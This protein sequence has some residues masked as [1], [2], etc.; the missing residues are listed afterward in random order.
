MTEA[1]ANLHAALGSLSEDDLIHLRRLTSAWGMLADFCFSDLVLYIQVE[2][3]VVMVNHI[4]PTTS[5][6]IYHSDLVGESRTAEQRPLVALAYQTGEKTAGE[7]DSVWLNN[8]IKVSCIPVRHNGRVIA[9]VAQ[10]SVLRGR[11]DPGELES[12]YGAIFDRFA[13]MIAAGVFPFSEENIHLVNMPRVGDG[14]VLVGADRSVEYTSPNA[15]SA[16]TRSGVDGVIRGTTLAES[17]FE[18]PSVRVALRTGRPTVDEVEHDDTVVAVRV[19][20]LLDEGAVTGA[21]VLLRDVTDLRRRDRLLLSKDA[22]IREIHHRVKNNL[23]TISSLLRLQGRRLEEPTAKAAIEESVRRIRT[24]AL[25][26]DMLSREPG[27]DVAFLSVL[28]PL[29][30]MVEEGLVSPDRPVSFTVDGDPGKLSAPVATSLSVVITEIL[31]NIVEHA[32]PTAVQLVGE[33]IVNIS[34]QKEAGELSVV[35]TDNGVGISDDLVSALGGGDGNKTSLG[36]SIVH[37]V[38]VTEMG[39]QIDFVSDGG[40]PPRVGTRVDIRVPIESAS[41]Q[42]A[43]LAEQLEVN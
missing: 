27:E 36:L 34:L 4:R 9:V 37:S 40:D 30:G 23:Q 32:F 24:I 12:N 10:E 26:H 22:T 43:D 39:G 13:T 38:V 35:I 7:I 25:V 6:T 8:R 33:S 15:T 42:L 11:S 14:V 31:Q 16:L 19:L 18:S 20:P 3:D 2:S 28:R 41:T 29:V 1:S 5:Q 17:G 21:V